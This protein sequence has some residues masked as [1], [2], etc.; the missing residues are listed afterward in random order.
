MIKAVSAL[1]RSKP[2]STLNP[3]AVHVH[4]VRGAVL[5]R[6]RDP[7]PRH[8][9]GRRPHG[10]V[11]STSPSVS[12]TSPSVSNTRPSVSNTAHSVSNSHPGVEPFFDAIATL[13]PGMQED[14]DL[15]VSERARERGERESERERV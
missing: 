3:N 12:T 5:R 14:V 2:F 4:R 13:Y 6:H 15:M 11:S 1:D 7:L 9:R 10:D 8:A